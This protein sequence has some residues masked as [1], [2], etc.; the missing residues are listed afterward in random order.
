MRESLLRVDRGG[1]QRRFRKALHRREYSVPMRN[2]LWHIDVG[3]LFFF[4]Q[5][6]TN[7]KAETVL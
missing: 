1:V 7:N 2:S 6:S 3:Y 5:A 4:F